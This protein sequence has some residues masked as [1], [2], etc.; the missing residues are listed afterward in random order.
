MRT[1]TRLGLSAAAITLV[2]FSA[3]T[4]AVET[5]VAAPDATGPTRVGLRTALKNCDFSVV[6]NAPVTPFVPM[7]YGQALISR[8][9]STAV[10]EVHLTNT[11]EPGMHFDVVLIQAPR[12]SSAPCGPGAPGTATTG[13]DLDGGGQA[14]VTVQA[15]IQGGTT[16]VWVFIQRPNPH[17][18]VPAEFYTSEFVVPV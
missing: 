3:M 17:S 2:N 15:P 8:S 6:N 10:A 16:G 18:Q 7:G 12:P 9:G 1:L 11:F 14:T 4:F 13:L 5:A